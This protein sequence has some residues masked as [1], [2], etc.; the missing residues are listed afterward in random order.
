M[1]T[2][3]Q[4]P[5]AEEKT[6]PAPSQE[7]LQAYLSQVLLRI[8][9]ASP[10]LAA[11][12]ES[13]RVQGSSIELSFYALPREVIASLNA[14]FGVSNIERYNYTKRG[15]PCVGFKV[16]PTTEDLAALAVDDADD[17]KNTDAAGLS[18]GLEKIE[19]AANKLLT[20][21]SESPGPSA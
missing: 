20:K 11:Y 18:A 7:R 15:H 17:H 4:A 16:T 10:G 14:I 12:L 1:D 8:F 2:D 5:A 6:A 19:V 9:N 13:S 3:T 21:P